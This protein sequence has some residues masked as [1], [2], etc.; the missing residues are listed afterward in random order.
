[1]EKQET[2]FCIFDAKKPCP[3]KKEFKLKPES[4]VE[5]CNIC[6]APTTG[7]KIQEVKMI[8]D[9]VHEYG[10][11]Q[12]ELGQKTAEAEIYKGL[13]QDN[14]GKPSRGKLSVP[15]VANNLK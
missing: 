7:I 4:L 14:R 9:V 1:M 5:F 3:V 15:A 6:K 10:Q 2:Y 13:Y 8:I 11:L 12:K